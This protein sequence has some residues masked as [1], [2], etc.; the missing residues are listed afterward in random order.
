[1]LFVIKSELYIKPMKTDIKRSEIYSQEINKKLHLMSSI[2]F[3][4]LKPNIE[5]ENQ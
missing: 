2:F 4:F 1:M 3:F 5:K